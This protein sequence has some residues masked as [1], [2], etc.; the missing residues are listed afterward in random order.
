MQTLFLAFANICRFKTGPQ[1]LPASNHLLIVAAVFSGIVNFIGYRTAFHGSTFLIIA[2]AFSDIVI[3]AA[4]YI[5]IVY[6]N[7]K[8]ERVVQT[9]TAIL[10]TT[11]LLSL[12]KLPIHL[13]A[14]DV[15]LQDASMQLL[16]FPIIIEV[17]MLAVI[18]WIIKNTLETSFGIG[19]F[20][21]FVGHSISKILL[22]SL[23]PNVLTL[24]P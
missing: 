24:N 4:V 8:P 20:V 5:G 19:V 3:T 12:L 22:L 9:L 7:R 6:L 11:A 21:S 15:A 16:F 10:G 18:A 1:D 14:P 13:F 17:W 2:V 23:Y